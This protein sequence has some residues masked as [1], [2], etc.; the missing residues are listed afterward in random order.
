[1]V[2]ARGVLDRLPCQP[3][4]ELVDEP[5]ALSRAEG[6]AGPVGVEFGE[7]LEV[8]VF[9]PLALGEEGAEGGSL[10]GIGDSD[11]GAEVQEVKDVGVCEV[12]W[13]E[14]GG[15]AGSKAGE[16]SG[17]EVGDGAGADGVVVWELLKGG[18]EAVVETSNGD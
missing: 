18:A 12:G 16:E 2:H 7:G 3:G 4:D 15:E 1:M 13:G 8:V 5:D 6:V 11:E 9:S 14:G 10:G 17:G